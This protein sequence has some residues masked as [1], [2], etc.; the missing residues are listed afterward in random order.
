MLNV[1]D[2]LFCVILLCCVCFCASHVVMVP[3]N[4]LLSALSATIS[5][6]ISSIYEY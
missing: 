5:L 6:N 1:C 3:L 2:V 4:L